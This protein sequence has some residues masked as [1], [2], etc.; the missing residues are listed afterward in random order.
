MD[1]LKTEIK[2]IRESQVRMEEDV[3]HHIKRTDDN[4]KMLF[5]MWKAFVGIKWCLGAIVVLGALAA[6]IA[7]IKGFL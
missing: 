2:L 6:S 1:E 5:P 4:E 7:K 3:K